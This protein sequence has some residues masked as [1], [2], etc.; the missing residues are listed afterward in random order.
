MPPIHIFV[1]IAA[2]NLGTIV[3]DWWNAPI[4]VFCL[5]YTRPCTELDPRYERMD[6][7]M[8][9]RRTNRTA[10]ETVAKKILD[11]HQV[12]LVRHFV[13][14][15]DQESG[16]ATL[17]SYDIETLRSLAT[18]A[19][20]QYDAYSATVITTLRAFVLR[21]ETRNM[22][23]EDCTR[24]VGQAAI[25]YEPVVV[26][27]TAARDEAFYHLWLC[28]NKHEALSADI[29]VLTDE[30]VAS[31]RVFMDWFFSAGEYEELVPPTPRD[32]EILRELTALP[33]MEY[34][35]DSTGVILA[36]EEAI[37]AIGDLGTMLN[38][39]EYGEGAM[40]PDVPPEE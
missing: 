39:L 12:E 28:F 33:I 15:Y 32:L 2:R 35:D 26:A 29:R 25:D 24:I 27:A 8:A 5:G 19:D 36:A 14:S 34:D 3:D 9:I 6:S 10:T 31:V 1:A 4:C 40:R 11:E 17:D 38:V 23:I 37:S 16:A 13:N 30:Q 22:L 7:T 20:M 18:L 21:E